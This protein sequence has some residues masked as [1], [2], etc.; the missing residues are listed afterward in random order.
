M[1]G[2]TRGLGS[3]VMDHLGNPPRRLFVVG[4]AAA[5]LGLLVERGLRLDVPQP[6]PPPPTRRKAPDEAL[7]LDVV[8]DLQVLIDGET[9]VLAGS[10]ANATVRR[11][12]TVQREQLRVFTG[13]LTNAGVPSAVINE[14]IAKA[15]AGSG[16]SASGSSGSSGSAPTA[17]TTAATGTPTPGGSST[18]STRPATRAPRIRTRAQLA[19]ALDSLGAGDWERVAQATPQTR[20]LV[21][22]AYGVRLAG[23]VL[24]GRDVEPGSPSPARAQIIARTQPLVYAF[25]VAAAQSRGD[26]RSRAADTLTALGRLGVALSSP[27]LSSPPPSESSGWALPFPVTTPADADR[28]ATEVLRTAVHA[29]TD[30]AGE[31]PTGGALEDV[32]RWTAHVQALGTRWDVPLTAFPGASK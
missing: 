18:S 3:R 29:S 6:V 11:L 32:G 7:L 24:L 17:T 19:A 2:G 20:E 31:K 23:A 25:E 22:A 9:A 14:A 15:R 12:R 13:R 28:L 27:A 30:A 4:G 5:V 8:A 1:D 10:G 26:E 21:A 16:T